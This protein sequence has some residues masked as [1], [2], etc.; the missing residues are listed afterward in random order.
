VDS[1]YVDEDLKWIEFKDV[2]EVG[3]RWSERFRSYGIITDDIYTQIDPTDTLEPPISKTIMLSISFG[4]LVIGCYPLRELIS[5]LWYLR[6][7]TA[8]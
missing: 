7:Q 3:R 6:E 4:K 5:M 8:L 1:S 2:W